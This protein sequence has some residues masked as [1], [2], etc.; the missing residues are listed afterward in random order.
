MNTRINPTTN[1]LMHLGHAYMALVNHHAAH[2]TGGRFVVRYDDNQVNWIAK[3]GQDRMRHFA[4]SWARDLMWLGVEPDEICYQSEMEPQV[5]AAI[6]RVMPGYDDMME[7]NI[8]ARATWTD[9]ALYPYAPFLTAEVVY[10]DAMSGINLLIAG[11]D[12][13]P[14][15]NLYCHMAHVF[16][17]H[18]IQHIYIPRLVAVRGGQLDN[19]SKTNGAHKVS[20]MRDRG[21]SAEEVIQL[22]RRSC[23]VNPD[24]DWSVDN[25]LQRPIIAEATA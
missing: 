12:L 4:H 24:G 22:L 25:L 7:Y 17:F 1:G 3:L 16:G 19:V 13:L 23:L 14:R 10:L 6:H 5:R 9:A 8:V 21:M 11:E 15:H 18:Q 2:S 20:A